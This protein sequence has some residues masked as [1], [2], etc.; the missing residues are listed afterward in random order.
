MEVKKRGRKPKKKYVVNDNPIFD[1]NTEGEIIIKIK[2]NTEDLDIDNLD[3]I[4][5]LDNLYSIDN[6][7]ID[8]TEKLC[9]NC[10]IGLDNNF[11]SLPVKYINEIFHLYGS[12][13]DYECCKK[14]TLNHYKYNKFEIYSYI[15]LLSDINTNDLKF[16]ILNNNTDDRIQYKSK[17]LKLYRNI[18][19]KNDILSMINN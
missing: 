14:Y 3:D 7:Y 8:D 2:N 9:M 18:K 6:L 5:D 17:N 16:K 15:N 11:K 13:C 1:N 12:F 10:S 19:K 4:S